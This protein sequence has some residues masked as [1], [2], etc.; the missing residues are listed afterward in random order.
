MAPIGA[1]FLEEGADLP[2]ETSP[3]ATPELP[4]APPFPAEILIH[5]STANPA[6]LWVTMSVN[7]PESARTGAR[8][9]WSVDG[10]PLKG[11]SLLVQSLLR[12]AGQ[13]RIE[14]F[15][16]TADNQA[17][18]LSRTVTVNAPTSQPAES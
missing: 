2:L 7:L 3:P 6:P 11:N 16:T 15:V 4:A 8:V 9:H 5:G 18:A 14:A 13:H 10:E 12:Q 1:G 17:F